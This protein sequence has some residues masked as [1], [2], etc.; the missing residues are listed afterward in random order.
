M[1]PVLG[2]EGDVAALVEETRLGN[3]ILFE[4]ANDLSCPSQVRNL[5]DQLV[6]VIEEATGV[7]PLIAVDQ[8]GGVVTR[9][10]SGFL[11]IPSAQ[12]MGRRVDEIEP[13][14]RKVGQEMRDVG[15]NMVLAPVIDLGHCSRCYGREG[16]WV[17]ECGLA[18]AQG[19]W[20]CVAVYKHFPG[21]GGLSIDPHEALPVRRE[22][23]ES[24]LEPFW[25]VRK[26]AE[27][28]MTAHVQ[29]PA[30]D[31]EN[32]ASLSYTM[33]TELLREEWGFDGVVVT[34]SLTM[35]GVAPDQEDFEASCASVAEAA[36]R[37]FNAGCDLLLLGGA[38]GIQLTGAEHNERTRRVMARFTEAVR[39]GQISR[40]RVEESAA[41]IL[42]LKQNRLKS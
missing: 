41:R 40:D 14:S 13:L 6:V 21:Y 22:D 18:V 26:E 19:L 16:G 12:E 29:V 42:A 34:D 17:A 3:V 1:A 4:W 27:A 23:W 7:V 38:H 11:P 39:K 20:P 10:R 33:I 36:I 32:P 28:I 5:T 25:Q 2:D 9:L 30:L 31:R 24:H 35:Q 15:V 37:A 8:E